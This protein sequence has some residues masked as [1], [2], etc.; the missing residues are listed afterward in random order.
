ML[1]VISY[2][3]GVQSTAMLVLSARGELP[4][5][6]GLFAN[7]GEDCSTPRH[8]PISMSGPAPM[9]KPTGSISW[10][11]VTTAARGKPAPFTSN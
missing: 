3:G 4:Y 5:R 7:V 11:S 10:S 6:V 9:R 1:Q 2:G 8:L